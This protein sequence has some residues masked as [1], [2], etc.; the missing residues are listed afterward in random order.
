MRAGPRTP[1][2][3]LLAALAGAC[4]GA[5][6]APAD[7]GLAV[8]RAVEEAYEDLPG[9]VV[10]DRHFALDGE[11]RVTVAAPDTATA[12]AALAAAFR[13][14]D[15]VES[16]VSVHRAGSEISR[17]NAAAGREPVAVGSWTET[18]LAASLDWA[19]R[20]GGAF[21]PTVGPLVNAWGFGCEQCAVPAPSRIR[22]ALAHVGWRKVEYDPAAHTVFLPDSDM[23]LDV[24]GAAK[25]FALDRMRD[26]MVE[27]GA[28]AGIADLGGDH[29]FFGEG[30][31]GGENLWPVDLLDPYA[32]RRAFARLEIPPGV[33][34]STSPYT[35]VVETDGGRVGHLIDPRD[36]QPAT[37][38]ASVTVYARDGI[39]SDILSTALFVLGEDEGC[40]MLRGWDEVGALFVIEP[41]PGGRSLVCVTRALRGRVKDLEPPFRPLVRDDD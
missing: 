4:A 10:T 25:G 30:T 27:A 31:E 6:R 8:R 26:A 24:R 28:T 32:P 38:L 13:A 33:V 41:R 19:R 18:L 5:P 22:D 17:I 16:L 11:M 12:R 40:D 23:R 34:S 20:T 36:G 14:A 2:L 3:L 7:S 35:R 9:V 1:S 29:L 15:S 39:Q 37:G 21:D